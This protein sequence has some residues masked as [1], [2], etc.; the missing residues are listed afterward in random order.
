MAVNLDTSDKY[1]TQGTG[2]LPSGKMAMLLWVNTNGWVLS[3]GGGSARRF[4]SRATDAGA[5]R[6]GYS[7]YPNTMYI[8]WGSGQA[9]G[10]NTAR[11]SV[12]ASTWQ[13]HILI[14]DPASSTQ[15]LRIGTL[16]S[17]GSVRSTTQTVAN[18]AGLTRRIGKYPTETAN[19]DAK[20]AH[21]AVMNTSSAVLT[22]EQLRLLQYTSPRLVPGL[23]LTTYVSFDSSTILE[24]VVY[25]ETGSDAELFGSPSVV[26]GPEIVEHR[27]SEFQQAIKDAL[28]ESGYAAALA[29]LGVSTTPEADLISWENF[30][31]IPGQVY[32]TGGNAGTSLWAQ[33][34]ADARAATHLIDGTSTLDEMYALAEAEFDDWVGTTWP[35]TWTD[36]NGPN[37]YLRDVYAGII[38]AAFNYTNGIVVREN[39]LSDK[40]GSWNQ[41]WW[42]GDALHPVKAGP[43]TSKYAMGRFAQTV[44]DAHGILIVGMYGEPFGD[45]QPDG[46]GGG[47]AGW[48]T[49]ANW[50]ADYPQCADADAD[51]EAWKLAGPSGADLFTSLAA[52]YPEQ[53]LWCSFHTG[54]FVG[55]D[56]TKASREAEIGADNLRQMEAAGCVG[57]FCFDIGYETEDADSMAW[58]LELVQRYNQTGPYAAAGGRSSRQSRAQRNTRASRRRHSIG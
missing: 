35:P 9:V 26:D 21:F 15:T 23:T 7:Y 16:T 4:F 41:G 17:G 52:A 25:P 40:V 45:L 51:L 48:R 27:L 8:G 24:N 18:D 44:R 11:D 57:C 55:T 19:F 20:V 14:L 5:E 42:P 46:S 30:P 37:N 43:Q 47:A 54:Y 49:R 31:D 3:S 39:C 28:A 32:R 56:A 1:I 2:T 6:F 33:S 29:A 10:S 58:W 53:D 34:E 13:P 50:L 38:G 22:A 12:V 36:T